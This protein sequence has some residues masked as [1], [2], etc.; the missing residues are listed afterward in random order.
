M[1]HPRS[2]NP[3]NSKSAQ[4]KSTRREIIL[5]SGG[6]FFASCACARRIYNPCIASRMRNNHTKHRL[7]TMKIRLFL[8][9]PL[10]MAMTLS[11]HAA[12]TDNFEGY[13]LGSDLHGQGNW[14]GWDSSPTAGGIVSDAYAYSATQSVNISGGSDLVG[15]FSGISGGAAATKTPSYGA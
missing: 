8:G 7:P 10:A 4:K 13:I 1:R 15:T 9:L 2:C 11:T 3:S 12:V 6:V 14:T 5:D